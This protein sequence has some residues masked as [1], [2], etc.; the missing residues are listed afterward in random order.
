MGSGSP[1]R[2]ALFGFRLDFLESA[3][4]DGGGRLGRAHGR[5]ELM[6]LVYSW[7]GEVP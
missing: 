5:V 1:S 7:L 2:F 4:I 3:V 6:L